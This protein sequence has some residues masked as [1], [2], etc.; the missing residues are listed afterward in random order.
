MYKALLRPLGRGE[1]LEVEVDRTVRGQQDKHIARVGQHQLEVELESIAPGRGWLRLRERVFPYCA[2]RVGDQVHVWLAGR[3]FALE[4]V[5][6]TPRRSTATAGARSATVTAPM[7]GTLLK[8]EVGPGE[9]FAAHQPLIVMESM[10][11]EM[12]LS[13]PHAGRIKEIHGEVGALVE[14][15]AVLA[16]LEDGDATDEP[17]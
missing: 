11:M 12:T 16:T 9:S 6:R 17:A 2:A 5:E 7:P 1:P 15:G 3:T 8:I 13:V 4:L 10:K 14:M